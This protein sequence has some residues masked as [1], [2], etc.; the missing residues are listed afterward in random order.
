MNESDP[1]PAQK[2]FIKLVEGQDW[3]IELIEGQEILTERYKGEAVPQVT[4][5]RGEKQTFVQKPN[6]GQS[7]VKILTYNHLDKSIRPATPDEI[8]S[9]NQQMQSLYLQMAENGCNDPSS[10]QNRWSNWN[11]I[12]NADLSNVQNLT[13]DD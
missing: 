13:G 4:K 1:K 10:D 7:R 2:V 9:F 5:R 6:P 3:E 11:E 12:S 8:A